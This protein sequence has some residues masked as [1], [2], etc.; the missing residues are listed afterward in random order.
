MKSQNVK[1]KQRKLTPCDVCGHPG[2][3]SEPAIQEAIQMQFVAIRDVFGNSSFESATAP[4]S[5]QFIIDIEC[6]ALTP[7]HAVFHTQVVANNMMVSTSQA[8]SAGETL[9]NLPSLII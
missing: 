2:R 5:Q 7:L 4:E 9:A 6:A 8:C 3:Q 1:S